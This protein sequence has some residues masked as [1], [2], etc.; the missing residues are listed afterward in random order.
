MVDSAPIYSLNEGTSRAESAAWARF[1]TAK[2][3]TEFWASWLAILCIQIE[4]V[5]GGLLLLGPDEKGAYAPAAVWPHAGR[6]LQ[7]LSATAQ[8]VLTE[9]RGLVVSPDG[10]TA[11][12]RDQR[13]FVGYPVEVGVLGHGAVVLDLGPGPEF[14]LLRAP[15]RLQWAS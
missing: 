15:R 7:Y 5:G 6:D 13:A 2:D 14:A 3:N 4:R 12:V 11:P 8:R 1:S 10:A 9:R